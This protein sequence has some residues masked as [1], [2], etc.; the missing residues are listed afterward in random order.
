MLIVHADDYAV[1]WNASKN[2]AALI[3]EGKL[4]STSVIP[5]MSCYEESVALLRDVLSEKKSKVELAIHIN[6]MEGHCVAPEAD[7]SL[8]VDSEGYFRLSW[9]DLLLASFRR[10]GRKELK[11]QLRIEIL[12]QIR[13]IQTDLSEITSF[14]IDSHQHTHMIPVV[15]DSLIEVLRENEFPV[16]CIRIPDEPLSPYFKEPSLW[17]SY[18]MINGVKNILLHFLSMRAGRIAPDFFYC[19]MKFWGL[20]MT[21]CMDEKRVSRL[22]PHF[23]QYSEEKKVDIEMVFHPGTTLPE[24]I[25]R[26]YTK[27]GFIEDHLSANR[28]VEYDTIWKISDRGV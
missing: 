25:G 4:N 14:R 3:A 2:I 6:L 26:E 24:E 5:N 11:Q 28:K 13:K 18:G 23:R 15:W 22:I 20:L 8:L 17:L 19:R 21:G 27:Q 16:S 9:G 7:E 10:K 1:S 12:A